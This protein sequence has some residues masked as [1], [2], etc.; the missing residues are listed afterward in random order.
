MAT[1]HAITEAAHRLARTRGAAAVAAE[2]VELL[3]GL[4]D[5]DGALLVASDGTVTASTGAG[6]PPLAW[7]DLVAA[8]TDDPLVSSWDGTHGPGFLVSV[9]VGTTPVLLLCAFR[10]ARFEPDDAEVA[11]V[12]A[13]HVTIALDAA[14]LATRLA[15]SE[16][17]MRL[18][19]DSVSD[20]VAVVDQ[21][22]RYVFASSSHDRELGHR[23]DALVGSSVTG[24]VHPADRSTVEASI[25]DAASGPRLEYRLR[26]ATGEWLWVESVLRAAQDDAVVVA[27]RVIED[28]RRL[29]DELRRTTTHDSLTGLASR[30]L[31][32]EWLESTLAGARAGTV[33]VLFCDI[34]QF[35]EVNDRL[36]HEAGDEL[37]VH[38]ADRLRECVRRGDLL[39]RFGGDEFVVV[40]DNPRDTD[41]MAEVA[42][43]IMTSLTRPFWLCGEHVQVSVCVGGA[44]ARRGATSASAMMRDADAALYAAKDH[45]RAQ[46]R[47]F[48]EAASLRS[49]DRLE[50]TSHLASA[51]DRGELLL[52]YQPIVTLDDHRVVGFEALA[53]WKHPTRGF[54]PPDVFIPIAED[55]GA[56]LE[57]GDWVLAQATRKLA[58]WREVLGAGG[59]IHMNVNLSAVQLERPD[60]ASRTLDIIRRAGAR[61]GDV[62][63]EVTEQR[64]I[65]G[66]V[67]PFTDA[68][69]AAGVHLALDDF[70][71][72]YSNLGHLERLPVE[73]L[74]IDRSF[75]DGMTVTERDHGIV[76]ACLAV[77]ESL[78]LSVVAEGIETTEQRDA[79]ISLGCGHGQGYLFSRPVPDTQADAIVDRLLVGS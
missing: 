10:G 67:T 65:R 7:A 60:A 66:D 31:C 25:A 69:L 63:L 6:L 70:G 54:I 43:R 29:E 36:G 35:K 75:V 22:G 71:M 19:A 59:A 50:V 27:S 3:A 53:R 55:T 20:L 18:I 23:A 52:H 77:A 62:W 37:L 15:E 78:G 17:S 32:S 76:R 8:S 13:A 14:E 39:A 49:R 41:A 74:K 1:L 57:I 42:E 24:L 48:D 73:L 33:G 40:L 5:A 11:A 46:V 51:L 34:D 38:V 16:A 2:A 30:A 58:Q 79:L 64:S 12:F 61:P 21:A 68:M 72:S 56:I 9:P 47:L 26:S 28:R 45:G 4:V 44:F